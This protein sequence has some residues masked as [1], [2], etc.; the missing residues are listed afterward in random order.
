[1]LVLGRRRRH[2]GVF[3]ERDDV[4]A[5]TTLVIITKVHPSV[6]SPLDALPISFLQM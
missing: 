3:K 4:V 5:Q 1:M 6:S 2:G